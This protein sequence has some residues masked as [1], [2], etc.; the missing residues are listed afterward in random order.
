MSVDRVPDNIGAWLV[1]DLAHGDRKTPYSF[2]AAV[3]PEFT[4]IGE[5]EILRAASGDEALSIVEQFGADIIVTN[6]DLA[7]SDLAL[8]EPAALA[9][10]EA[11]F[12]D[13]TM[14]GRARAEIPRA[15]VGV[16]TQA[17]V[18]LLLK[19]LAMEH[20]YHRFEVLKA[21]GKLR[22]GGAPLDFDE[23]AVSR[24]IALESGRYFKL[25]GV[26]SL[27]PTGRPE[28]DLLCRAIGETQQMRLESVFRL[29][30]LLYPARDV[31]NAYHGVMSGRRV[32]RANAQEFLDNL[33]TGRHR[34]LVLSLID[35]Q[36][37]T[38]AWLE[39]AVSLGFD[40]GG[41][42]RTREEALDFLA[43]GAD[44]WLCACAM[45]AG[46]TNT[47]GPAAHFLDKS[48][49]DMLSPIEK[50]LVLQKV[51]VFSEVPTAQLAALAGIARE[52]SVMADEDIY[53]EHDSPDALYLVLEGSVKLHQGERLITMAGRL[54]PFGTWALFDE[55]PRVMTATAAEDSRLMRIDRDEFIDL[56]SDEVRIAQGIIKTVAG[57]LRELADRVS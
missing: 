26:M 3:P 16:P 5:D 15:L 4:E 24:Q 9:D 43:S 48:G 10:L 47:G 53:R 33:L 56:L 45:F 37:A 52:V 6:H 28:A 18:D 30:G 36:P 55:E 46:A 23:S 50:V 13:E 29:L 38:E 7:L 25:A 51:D 14:S 31:L 12:V 32:L 27:L 39:A 41:E 22:A 34:R 17:A 20:P 2:V 42:I 19:H 40:P 49:A 11:F 21:L 57:R 54:T 44:P 1:N 35:E 8:G